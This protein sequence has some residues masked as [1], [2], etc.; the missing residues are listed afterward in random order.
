MLISSQ[1]RNKV[2]SVSQSL[3]LSLSLFVCLSPS[4]CLSVCFCLSL[5][6]SVFLS[7]S[8][9]LSVCLCVSLSL[10]LCLCLSVSLCLCLSLCLSRLK[11]QALVCYRLPPTSAII[12]ICYATGVGKMS[13]KGQ[14]LTGAQIVVWRTSPER[15]S[16]RVTYVIKL[17][18]AYKASSNGL[19]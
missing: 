6:V 2:Q 7:L 17:P 3:S 11:L 9:C 16:M 1:L 12:I 5:P 13:A 10:S 4:V 19:K 14:I 15:F 8:V 18:K